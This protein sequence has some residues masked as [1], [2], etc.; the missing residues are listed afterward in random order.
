M[1]EETGE[2]K[3]AKARAR[4][5]EGWKRV[6]SFS[7]ADVCRVGKKTKYRVR[8]DREKGLDLDDFGQAVAY[9]T[10]KEEEG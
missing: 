8:T 3:K 1:S 4:P 6:F 9:V 2:T 5:R 10:K 7:V